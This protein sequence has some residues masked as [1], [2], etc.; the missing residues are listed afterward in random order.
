MSLKLFQRIEKRLTE[1]IVVFD[2]YHKYNSVPMEQQEN[3][4]MQ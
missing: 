3:S 4:Q 1:I 2:T